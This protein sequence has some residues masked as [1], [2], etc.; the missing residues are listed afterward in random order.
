MFV[1]FVGDVIVLSGLLCVVCTG[2]QEVGR[3]EGSDVF[4]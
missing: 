3:E 4:L 2:N 1:W